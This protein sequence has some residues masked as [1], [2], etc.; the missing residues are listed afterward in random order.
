[1]IAATRAVLGF[2]LG[3]LLGEKLNRDERRAAGWALVAAGALTT[4]PIAL[5]IKG[6]RPIIREEHPVV[7]AA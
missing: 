7:L 1:M 6:K 5:G 3:L 4:I 2:G